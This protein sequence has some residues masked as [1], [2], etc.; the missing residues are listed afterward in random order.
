[1]DL[2]IVRNIL[3]EVALQHPRDDDSEKL[4]ALRTISRIASEAPDQLRLI[5]NTLSAASP[6]CIQFVTGGT[7]QWQATLR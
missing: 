4:K 2:D 6:C 5:V 1:M 7:R 3:K